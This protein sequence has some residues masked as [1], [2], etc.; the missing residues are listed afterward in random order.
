M[1]LVGTNGAIPSKI[2]EGHSFLTFH[3]F[4]KF[5]LNGSSLRGNIR[6]NVFQSDRSRLVLDKYVSSNIFFEHF[7]SLTFQLYHLC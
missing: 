5:R 2:L 4:A 3:A 7:I 6:V 1:P